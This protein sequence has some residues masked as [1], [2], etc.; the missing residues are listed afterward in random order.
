MYANAPFPGFPCSLRPVWRSFFNTVRDT[1]Y[2]PKF[3]FLHVEILL[4]QQL[5]KILFS[6]LSCLYTFVKN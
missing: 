1:G 2:A 6:L 4:C 5:L 3:I